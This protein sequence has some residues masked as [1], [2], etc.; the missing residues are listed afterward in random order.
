MV[1]QFTNFIYIYSMYFICDLRKESQCRLGVVEEK[2]HRNIF[3]CGA[4]VRRF[5]GNLSCRRTSRN[6]WQQLYKPEDH[7]RFTVRPKVVY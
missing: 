2:V 7:R 6:Q 3:G 4:L 5:R 1:T